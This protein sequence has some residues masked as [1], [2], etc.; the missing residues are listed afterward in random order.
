MA[1]QLKIFSGTASTYLA[2]KIAEL[3]GCPLGSVTLSR[4]SDGEIQP[5]YNE[6]VRGCDLF[7]IQSTFSPADNLMELLLMID[8][9]KRASVKSINVVIPYFGYARQDRK[10]K[11]R[12]SLGAKLVANLLTAAGASRLITMDLHAGQIQGFFD[13]PVDHLDASAVFLPFVRQHLPTDQLTIC[14]PDMGGVSRARIYAKFLKAEIAV[15]DKHRERANQV[16]S[17]QVIGEVEGKDVILVDDLV[18]TAGTLCKAAG[19]L[20]NRGARSVRAFV[21]HP[22]LSGDAIKKV[23][24]SELLELVVTDTIPLRQES[25]KIR[26]LSIAP[27]FSKAFRKIHNFESISSLFVS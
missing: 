12:V 10:D 26:V 21:T 23:E 27:V 2:E 20:K 9:A 17:M 25:S 22:I 13:I 5:S 3:Y 1:Y 16:A 4:F 7:L 11:P 14:A 19:E 15:I 24:D 6:S 8:A 18:D